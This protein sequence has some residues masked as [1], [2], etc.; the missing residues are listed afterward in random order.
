MINTDDIYQKFI[1]HLD[2][3]K[4][5]YKLFNHKPVFNYEDS[6]EVQKETGFIGTEGK[7]LV[8][9]T[10]RTRMRLSIWF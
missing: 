1:N 4:V 2:S 7:C 8:L 5:S 10:G 6:L 3:N 9:K